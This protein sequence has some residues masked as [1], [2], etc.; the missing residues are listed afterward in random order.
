MIRQSSTM[1]SVSQHTMSISG[2]YH[3]IEYL[4]AMFSKVEIVTKYK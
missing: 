4:E 3:K 2:K 1:N